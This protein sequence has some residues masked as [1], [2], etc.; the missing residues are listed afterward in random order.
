MPFVPNSGSFG[1]PLALARM[2]T[3]PKDLQTQQII[4]K[5]R[6]HE[7]CSVIE[8]SQ[9][10]LAL[11]RKAYK[12]VWDQTHNKDAATTASN[13][14]NDGMSMTK[15]YDKLC[16]DKI[17]ICLNVKLPPCQTEKEMYANEGKLKVLI[18]QYDRYMTSMLIDLFTSRF[19]VGQAQETTAYVRWPY[20]M[21][22]KVQ[23]LGTW[24]CRAEIGTHR[25]HAEI[26]YDGRKKYSWGRELTEWNV[27]FNGHAL[28]SF[29]K[30]EL[31]EI[32]DE[33]AKPFAEK[34]AEHTQDVVKYTI[35]IDTDDIDLV[36]L[37]MLKYLYQCDIDLVENMVTYNLGLR[38]CSPNELE[39]AQAMVHLGGMLVTAAKSGVG[40]TS[41][42]YVQCYGVKKYIAFP[43]SPL[44]LEHEPGCKYITFDKP[45][46]IN[47]APSTALVSDGMQGGIKVVWCLKYSSGGPAGFTM[48]DQGL[49]FVQKLTTGPH[50]AC[51]WAAAADMQ[52]AMGNLAA[53][54]AVM[55]NQGMPA[56]SSSSVMIE[57]AQPTRPC[58]QALGDTQAVPTLQ[59][60]A[61][62]AT[63][64]DAKPE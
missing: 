48:L 27:V 29:S 58:P 38:A 8:D 20:F 62:G 53:R 4:P 15:L 13:Q 5:E 35:P 59:L 61:D 54:L 10:R 2:A 21:G 32:K 1:H 60:K 11:G 34:M 46:P 33:M 50:F 24:L 43:D 57:P 39:Q 9:T 17:L 25:I 23:S 26:C 31:Q 28:P 36:S 47:M 44:F 41:P 6:V 64:A 56:A 55:Q 51:L 12:A 16:K 22:D 63:G 52:V 7:I 37:D 30:E 14:Y 40:A 49:M 3:Q 42:V 19:E 18:A 45:I